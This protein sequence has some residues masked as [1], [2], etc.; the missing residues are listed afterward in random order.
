MVR[1]TRM[2]IKIIGGK[3]YWIIDLYSLVCLC[4]T[5][6]GL[7]DVNQRWHGDDW[8]LPT[9]SFVMFLAKM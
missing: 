1:K 9:L 6:H 5:E 2:E 3:L 8:Q 4:K 7:Y